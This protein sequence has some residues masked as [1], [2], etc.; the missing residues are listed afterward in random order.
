MTSSPTDWHLNGSAAWDAA[1]R[2][3]VL[4]PA[5]SQSKGSLIY[6]NPVRAGSFTVSFEFQITGAGLAGDGLIFGIESDGANVI[7]N[8]G[9]GLGLAGVHG[10][11]FEIDTY[12]N[13]ECSDGASNH[14]GVDDLLGC[15]EGG[16]GIVPRTLMTP[17]SLSVVVRNSGWHR[18]T[19]EVVSGVVTMK[20]DAISFI[21]NFAVPGL[22][23]STPYYFAF[24]AGTGGS[25]DRHEIRNVSISLPTPQCL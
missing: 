9:A 8:S 18:C 13:V 21:N 19:V 16:S 10:F 17:V 25:S 7:G 6:G 12:G 5:A 22:D 14:V 24:G 15:Q 2:S 11:G 1:A 4:T 20:V 3:V 23:D